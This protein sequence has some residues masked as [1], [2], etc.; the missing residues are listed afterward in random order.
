MKKNIRLFQLTGLCIGL[1]VAVLC[2]GGC[3]QKEDPTPAFKTP[4]AAIADYLNTDKED[5]VTEDEVRDS[6]LTTF[7]DGD[8]DCY[9]RKEVTKSGNDRQILINVIGVN[10]SED[11]Y[12]CEKEERGGVMTGDD[13]TDETYIEMS[14]VIH[15]DLKVLTGVVFGDEYVPYYDGKKLDVDEDGI[16][17]CVTDSSDDEIEW[18]GP[19]E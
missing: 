6:I 8:T 1:I 15:K 12:R 5:K 11:G 19:E 3:G 17:V 2:L 13:G 16:Y 10:G 14:I 7:K 4:E 9:V 18:E